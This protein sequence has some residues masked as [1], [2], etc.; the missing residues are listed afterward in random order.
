MRYAKWMITL[1]LAACASTGDD[2]TTDKVDDPLTLTD[3]TRVDAEGV[4]GYGTTVFAENPTTLLEKGDFHGY[5]F[6]GKAGG[7]VTITMTAKQCGQLDTLVHLFGPEDANESRGADLTR[8][9]DSGGLPCNTDSQIAG[10]TLPVDGEY[11]IVATSFLQRGGGH[12]KLTL[13]CDNGACEQP[14]EMTFASSRIAQADIDR[15]ALSAD[16]LFETGDFLFE[17]IFKLDDGLGNALAGAPAGNAPRPNFRTVHQ[18]GFGAP[19]AQSCITCHNVGGDDGAGDL[20]HNIFQIG[21][22]ISPASGLPRNAPVVLGNGLRQQIG[23]EMT[24]ELQAQ[25]AAAKSQ[26]AAQAF[27]VTK[28]LTAKGISFGSILVSPNGTVDTAGLQGVDADL[29][30]KPFGWKGREATLRRFVEGG[31]RVHFGMQTAPSIAKHC[32]TPDPQTFGTGAD[33]HD[34]DGDGVTDEITEGQLT[35]M[36]VYMGLRETP[37]RVPAATDAARQ[38]AQAGEQLFGSIGC[39]TC[40]VARMR[41]ASPTHLEPPDT[42]GGAG[43]TLNLVDDMRSPHPGRESDGSVQVEL[44]SDFKRHDMGSALADSKPFKTIPPAQFITTPLWGVATSAPYMHDGRS[45]TLRDAILAHAGEALGS[46]SAF[47]ALSSDDQQKVVDFLSTL[48][49]QE[50]TVTPRADGLDLS[51]FAVTQANSSATF[52][53]PAG[54]IVPHGGY[55][56]IARNATR[57]QFQMFYG[58]NLDANVTF[59][60]TGNKFPLINGSET[61][62]LSNALGALVE[63][64]T[65]QQ[66]SGALQIFQRVSGA[67]PAGDRASWTIQAARPQ[68]ATPGSGQVS[69]GNSRVYISEI[70]DASGTGNSGFEFVEVFVE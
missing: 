36:A 61:Y 34:P 48:G 18:G 68:A 3:A 42:T 1:P 32:A 53:V 45:P 54:T 39:G 47:S 21:D 6:H 56:V 37:V 15:G 26:A 52:R 69:T 62:A 58:H 27:S 44:W 46:R 8:A 30:V 28:Q 60:N 66:A 70:A 11:L 41:L 29:V 20:N 19:E 51:G 38:R 65:A 33:C 7:V 43:I 2:S 10:F 13:T 25:L 64:P 9:D 63:G 35:A 59:I 67:A 31:F 12:Y 49:R 4:L 57:E 23:I 40:H 50:A 55:V 24:A 5:E 17:N 22:G 16:D 14:G